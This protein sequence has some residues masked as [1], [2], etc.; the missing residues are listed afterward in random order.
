MKWFRWVTHNN[1]F[2]LYRNTSYIKIIIKCTLMYLCFTI[3]IYN[4]MP[5]YISN[6]ELINHNINT[7]ENKY[8]D[9]SV[10][11]FQE[12]VRLGYKILW[13]MKMRVEE[14]VDRDMFTLPPSPMIIIDHSFI[15]FYHWCP[16]LYNLYWPYAQNNSW[17]FVFL[18]DFTSKWA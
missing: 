3:N 16:V 13:R 5:W 17:N 15:I 4:K 7:Q 18:I 8:H 2:I 9:L 10:N 1:L 11:Y 12:S 6:H 14:D